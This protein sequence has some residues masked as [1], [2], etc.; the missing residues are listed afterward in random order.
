MG[1]LDDLEK[2]GK[3]IK[4][5]V[6][7]AQGKESPDDLPF[8]SDT[9]LVPEDTIEKPELSY[10]CPCGFR[11]TWDVRFSNPSQV[12]TQIEAHIE[13]CDKAKKAFR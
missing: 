6:K 7:M 10:K 2:F 12:T 11:C 3:A 5:G 8:V 4:T 9:D 13:T 1:F